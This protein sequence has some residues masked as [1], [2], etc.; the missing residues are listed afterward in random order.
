MSKKKAS[1]ATGVVDPDPDWIQISGVPG[2][3]FRSAKMTHK[4]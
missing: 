3:G 4:K 1:L 2:S